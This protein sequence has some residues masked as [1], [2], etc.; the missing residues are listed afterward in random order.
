MAFPRTAGMSLIE[1]LVALG[2]MVIIFGG[3]FLSYS[4]I[5]DTLT[6]SE[7]R[8]AA[9]TILNREVEVAR[10]IPYD[11]VGIVNGVPSG[12]LSRQK[13]AE[14]KNVDFLIVTTVRNIDDPFDGV[15][16]GTPNDTAPADY[17]LVEVE[18]SCLQCK[19]FV[20]ITL[21]TTV[22][23]K[24]L[25]SAG[26][27]G[28]LFI[29]A[30]SPY[31][32]PI[33]GVTVHVVNSDISPT[34]DLYDMTNDD[35]VLQLVGVP[36]STDSYKIWVS[37]PGF[38]SDQTYPL[39]GAGNPN[40]VH[41]YQT[42]RT[43]ER[44]P[45]TFY[46]DRLTTTTVATSRATCEPVPNVPFSFT[47]SRLI[48]TPDVVKNATT[49][50]TDAAGVKTFTDF[51]WDAYGVSYTVAGLN[52]FAAFPALPFNVDPGTSTTLRL[53]FADPDP[54]AL[55]VH[56]VRAGSLAPIPNAY[57]TLTSG[58]FNRT[59]VT[60]RTSL[61]QTTWVG[62]EYASESGGI[63]T[64]SVPGSFSLAAPYPTST[65]H[66]L[67]SRTFDTGS[68]ST[69]L[70]T[71]SWT[72]TSQPPAA[73]SD[74]LRFQVAANN[75]DATWNFVGPDGTGATYFTTSGTALPYGL[76]GN[77]Y[78]RYRAVLRTIDESTTPSVDWVGIEY[79][80]VCVPT[81]SAYLGGLGGGT[82]DVLATAVGFTDATTTVTVGT[83][84]QDLTI[85]MSQ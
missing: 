72:P 75:D 68:A 14:W 58:E 44:T 50:A 57:V 17:K 10:N 79:S 59:A 63:D 46:T 8:N 66:W 11:D 6:N 43:G 83:A 5:L 39:G 74:P 32:A 20:P 31:G 65:E 12:I 13:T 37:K 28:S 30:L 33:S 84:W 52:L 48:G 38:S 40:P 19:H 26:D 82:Y 49:S 53:V 1:L 35:G 67:I 54:D 15:V 21:T 56:V 2:L 55:S 78:V 36:T 24:N 4:S 47:G 80:G 41:P 77:R 45:I 9:V 23:P 61:T 69:T 85:T 34:I 76:S 16:G 18:V 81:G 42:V 25:E 22:A 27:S 73:G 3:A 51:E 64:T 70:F 7:L 62:G 71:L 60:G 29:Y